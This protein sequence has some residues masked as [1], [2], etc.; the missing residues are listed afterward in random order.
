MNLRSGPG[1]GRRGRPAPEPSRCRY[2][3]SNYIRNAWYNSRMRPDRAPRDLRVPPAPVLRARARD[4]A[5]R[6][7]PGSKPPGYPRTRKTPLGR[8]ADFGWR[9]GRD[10][11]ACYARAGLRPASRCLRNLVPGVRASANP[12]SLKTRHW[13][14]FRALE[15]S[16]VQVHGMA[17]EMKNAP[18]EGRGFRMVVREGLEPPARGFSAGKTPL[19][20]V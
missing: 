13:R 17:L 1:A 6:A 16:R 10:L 19:D 4:D 2:Y 5:G 12:F 18:R 9:P 11:R 20:L 8:G 3:M 7:P 14:V 15:S